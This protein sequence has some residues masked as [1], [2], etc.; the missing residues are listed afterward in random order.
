MTAI[1]MDGRAL[2]QETEGR[3]T[4]EARRLKSSGVEPTLATILVGDDQASKVYVG[5]KH[6][7]AGRVGIASVSHQLP[8]GTSAHELGSLI[9]EL[10]SDGRINGILLQLPLPGH[11]NEREMV[12]RIDPGKDVDGLTS[13][14]TG[15]LF[16]GNADLVPCTPKGVLELLHRYRIPIASASAVIINRSA[17]VGR[18]LYHLLLNEDAT[19]T[20]CHSKSADLPSVT[21]KA[22]IVVSAV[23]TRPK[24]VLTGD[25]VKEGAVV[26]DVAMNRVGGKLAG[27]ADFEEVSRRASYITPVPGGV[28]PMTVVMLLQNTLIA[29]TKQSKLLF[30][31]VAQK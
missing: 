3:L 25:M 27:D 13:A 9:D 16:Y 5:S 31:T 23:G 20:T 22:D 11:L 24:F 26:I 2:A 18:P 10:N 15:R 28:G 29:A 30:P 17:L 12:E 21:R 8:E 6:K 4:D 14:N 1:I 7:A 19:V